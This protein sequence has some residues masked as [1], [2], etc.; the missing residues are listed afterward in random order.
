MDESQYLHL[1]SIAQRLIAAEPKRCTLTATGLVHEL[2]L[3][4]L[5]WSQRRGLDSPK[6]FPYATR[7][8]RQILID[9][10]RSRIARDRAERRAMDWSEGGGNTL[11]DPNRAAYRLVALQHAVAL[12]EQE[13]PHMAELVRLQCFDDLSLEESAKRLG[14]SRATAYRHWAF[15]K[16]WIASHLFDEPQEMESQGNVPMDPE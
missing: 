15:C 11:H 14:I 2:Y 6:D 10:A 9:R 7:I 1:R 16:A 8:M 12:L 5:R 4:M 3:K 13:S